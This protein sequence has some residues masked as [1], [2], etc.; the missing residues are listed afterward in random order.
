MSSQ[1][2]YRNIVLTWNNYDPGTVGTNISGSQ[3]CPDWE[4]KIRTFFADFEKFS[5]SEQIAPDTGT[6]HIQGAG[7]LN[8]A[9]HL[10]AMRAHF[11]P[12]QVFI[13]PMKDKAPYYKAL[14]Y[15]ILDDKKS[16]KPGGKMD[17]F[18][19]KIKEEQPPLEDPL[20][21][22]TYLPWQQ[23]VVD[24]LN[25]TADRRHIYW[26]YDPIG[27]SGKSDLSTHLADKGMIHPVSG[28]H[29]HVLYIIQQAVMRKEW[30]KALV[31]DLPRTHRQVCYESMEMMKNGDFISTKYEGGRVR[32][33]RPHMFIFSNNLPNTTK[34]SADRW[35]IFQIDDQTKDMTEL[36]GLFI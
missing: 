23:K 12:A 30:I 18:G 35:R 33:N 31:Y 2:K 8:N 10:T 36:K 6:P 11:L 29:E 26:I 3:S 5:W 22:L 7:I 4:N 34:L 17:M 24:I 16:N 13:K 20:A 9:R 19:W 25:T 21:G 28:S 32:Y 1:K 15:P 14:S 27:S